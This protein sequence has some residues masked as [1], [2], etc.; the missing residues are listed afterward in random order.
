MP[1]ELSVFAVAD[2]MLARGE[3]PSLRKVRDRLA[4]GGSP[5]GVCEHLRAWR[6]KRGYDPKLEPTDMSKDMKAAGQALAMDLWKLAKREAT[7]AF[8]REREAAA[9]AERVTAAPAPAQPAPQAPVQ[10][11]AVQRDTDEE[12]A[13]VQRAEA[14]EEEEEET[15]QGTFVQREGAPEEEQEE[16]PAG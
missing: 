7:L 13:P 8:S 6:K 12:A 5:R 11:A 4:N 9:N 10:T 2:A 15:A 1:S 3:K 14:P 16:E